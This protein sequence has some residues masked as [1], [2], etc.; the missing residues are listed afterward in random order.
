MNIKRI[1]DYDG[2][3]LS[4]R[5]AVGEAFKESQHIAD[6]TVKVLRLPSARHELP[7]NPLRFASIAPA[8]SARPQKRWQGTQTSD[9]RNRLREIVDA[10]AWVAETTEH[11]EG[12]ASKRQRLQDVGSTAAYPCELP[13]VPSNGTGSRHQQRAQS[14]IQRDSSILVEDSQR[15]PGRKGMY[16]LLQSAYGLQLYRAQPLWYTDFSSYSK[17]FPYAFVQ[18]G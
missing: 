9:A 1:Q 17:S 18:S 6:R 15:S 12:R 2:N 4:C 14:H 3:T 8:S 7:N 10:D 16:I 5:L 13:R 11:S